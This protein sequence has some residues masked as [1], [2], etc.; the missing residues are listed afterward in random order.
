MI[1][2][3][4]E[5]AIKK[6]KMF[7]DKAKT[8]RELVELCRKYLKHKGV[9]LDQPDPVTFMPQE[10][11]TVYVG[12]SDIVRVH[13]QFICDGF[14]MAAHQI[15][16]ARRFVVENVVRELTEQ[17]LIDIQSF[18]KMDTYQTVVRGTLH[19]WRKPNDK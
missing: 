15:Q 2:E 9:I 8:D 17:N 5:V 13:G 19:A 3:D 11:K 7:A 6:F 18:R 14:D 1:V 4:S 10:P 12:T 16:Y